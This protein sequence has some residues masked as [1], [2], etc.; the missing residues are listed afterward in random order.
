[1]SDLGVIQDGAVLI[2]DGLLQEV[3]PSRR[4]ENLAGIRDAVEINAAGCV[5]MPGFVDSHT[6]LAFPLSGTGGGP[7]EE[8]ARAVRS[9]AGSRLM[10]RMRAYLEAMARHGTTTVEVKTGSGPDESAETKLLRVLRELRHDPLDVFATFFFQLPEDDLE[11]GNW[12]ASEWVVS[13]LLPKLR[14]RRLARFADLA[15]NNKPTA[16]GCFASY[17]QTARA[18]GFGCRIHADQSSA[19]AALQMAVEHLAV[20]VDHLEYAS[21]ANAP[22]LAG[23]STVATLLPCYS[24]NSGARFAPARDLID[25]GAAVALATN[26][27]PHHTPAL[28]MQTAIALACH[29]M[30]MTPEEALCAATLNGAHA[31]GR[32]HRSGSLEVGKEADLLILNVSDHRELAHHFGNNLVR[33]TMKRGQVIYQEGQV[34]HLSEQL[35]V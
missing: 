9:G 5:V 27:N 6:H 18:L 22:L 35:L 3:G 25:A 10:V 11:G 23:A 2:S 26:F 8:S 17:L 7:R 15:W 33:L 31:L 16:Y 24:F 19:T 20:S 1:M 28:S 21:A 29:Y 4:L 14:R 30:G 32:A 12:A 13:D 34:A